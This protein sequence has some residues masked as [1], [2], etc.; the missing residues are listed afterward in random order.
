MALRIFFYREKNRRAE[1]SANFFSIEKKDLRAVARRIFFYGEKIRELRL[2][3]LFSKQFFVALQIFFY[4]EQKSESCGHFDFFSMAKPE[5]SSGSSLNRTPAHPIEDLRL[6]Y[7]K[8]PGPSMRKPLA[9][10][11]EDL[12]LFFEKTSGP[13][14]RRPSALF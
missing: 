3:E 4:R 7:E 5:K 10:H 8:T 6:S 1:V 14:S 13:S 2:C 9:L 11:R 12:G